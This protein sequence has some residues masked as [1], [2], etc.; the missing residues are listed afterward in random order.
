M[1][2]IVW[3]NVTFIVNEH[4][5]FLKPDYFVLWKESGVH[6]IKKLVGLSPTRGGV[7]GAE[8]AQEPRNCAESC[9]F[10]HAHVWKKS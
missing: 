1:R 7:F 6:D 5:V 8:A 3:V 4:H 2:N 9:K 10:C